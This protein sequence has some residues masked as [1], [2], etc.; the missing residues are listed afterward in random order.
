[1]SPK[2]NA[3]VRNSDVGVVDLPV[4]RPVGRYALGEE[5]GCVPDPRQLALASGVAHG[6]VPELIAVTD[7]VGVPLEHRAVKG[8]GGGVIPGEQLEPARRSVLVEDREP[9]K[10]PR[11]P[12][13]QGGAGRV[14]E[15]GRRA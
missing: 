9:W 12:G 4:E 8:D 14:D 7:D 2:A 11:L 13:A 1:M 3:L 6:R 5:R 10:G 15:H